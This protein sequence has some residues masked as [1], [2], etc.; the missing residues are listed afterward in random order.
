MDKEIVVAIIAAG[1]A[2]LGSGLTSLFSYLSL[3]RRTEVTKLREAAIQANKDVIAFHNLEAMYCQLLS[4]HGK[5]SPETVKRHM[6]KQLRDAGKL[7]PSDTAT[8]LQAAKRIKRL[9]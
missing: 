9:T 6:R 7:S 3:K 4:E 1:S 5:Q 8:A 2:L